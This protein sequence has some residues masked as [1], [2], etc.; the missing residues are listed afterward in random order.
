ML[1]SDHYRQVIAL[2]IH[3]ALYIGNIRCLQEAHACT[4]MCYSLS[5]TLVHLCMKWRHFLP[6]HAW[7]DKN[8][9]LSLAE[10]CVLICVPMCVLMCVPMCVLMCVLV[11]VL[12]CACA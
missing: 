2:Y 12:M 6:A 9:V 5:Y 10:L 11:C 4:I 8:P 3:Y 7:N 1:F